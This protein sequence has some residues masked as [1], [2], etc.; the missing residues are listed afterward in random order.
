MKD[1]SKHDKLVTEYIKTKNKIQN[2][3]HSE[4]L[5]E[6]SM[7]EDFGK[8]FKPIT[9]QQQKSSEEIVS[10]FAPLQEAIE[11]MPVQQALPWDMPQPELE[12]QAEALAE[13]DTPQIE[14]NETSLAGEYLE[15]YIQKREVLIQRLE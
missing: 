3:F 9:E 8:I 4:R 12:G 15:K 6:Q 2:D 13:L 1:S 5:G 14:L 10:K 11:N 7:Y